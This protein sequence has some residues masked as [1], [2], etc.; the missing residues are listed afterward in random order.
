MTPTIIII[1]PSYIMGGQGSSVVS[2]C[3]LEGPGIT[4]CWR[5]NFSYHPDRTRSPP[6]FLCNGYQVFP[7]SKAAGAWCWPTTSF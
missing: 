6:S 7:G 4:F 1:Y 2:H 3:G 5:R